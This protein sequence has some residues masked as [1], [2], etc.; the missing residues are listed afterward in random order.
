[1]VNIYPLSYD[2]EKETLPQ[3]TIYG[4]HG[5]PCAGIIGAAK[6]DIGIV[7]VAYDCSL[8]SISNSLKGV[9]L[10]QIRRGY[11][12]LWAA[13]HG[14]DVINCSW[15]SSVQ[16]DEIDDAIVEVVENGRNGKG[17]LVIFPAGNSGDNTVEYPAN[18]SA[19]ISVGAMSPCGGKN[20]Q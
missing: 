14:A 4:V 10:S 20:S 17:C 13:E 5:V 19:V 11:G 2:S 16:H 12:I 6:N 7:G 9:P 15:A 8:M 3:D 1:V 18:L